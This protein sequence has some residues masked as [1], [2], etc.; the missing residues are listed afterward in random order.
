MYFPA[1]YSMMWL[2]AGQGHKPHSL[3]GPFL[4]CVCLLLTQTEAKLTGFK[5]DLPSS[6]LGEGLYSTS[7]LQAFPLWTHKLQGWTCWWL[8]STRS[9]L[10]FI[11]RFW[12]V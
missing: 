9:L 7:P 1:K 12:E 6:P 2:A 10:A 5:A 3:F 8:G 11:P 4:P